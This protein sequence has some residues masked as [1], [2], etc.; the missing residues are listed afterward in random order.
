MDTLVPIVKRSLVSTRFT[1]GTNGSIYVPVRTLESGLQV[2]LDL[3]VIIK[4][5]SIFDEMPNRGRDPKG[6]VEDRWTSVD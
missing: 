3:G 4:S 5:P 6:A 1:N 2:L